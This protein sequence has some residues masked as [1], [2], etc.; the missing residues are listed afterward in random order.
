MKSYAFMCKISDLKYGIISNFKKNKILYLFSLLLSL[1]GL[2]TGI[3]VAFK[4]GVTLSTLNDFNLQIYTCNELASFNYF[5][6]RL[7]SYTLFLL[8]LFIC[9]LTVYLVPVGLI[10]IAYRTYLA[11]FNC[12]LLLTLFGISGALTSI[13]I[14]LPFQ[15]IITFLYVIYFILTINRTESKKRFGNCDISF[16]KLF[17]SFFIILTFL[18]LI[19]TILLIALN[20][21]IIFTL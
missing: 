12:T 8:I 15:L 4:C 5:F 1:V 14:I 20:A 13:I 7:I 9:S 16:C 18:N 21:S 2:L 3:F 17:F 19:Q 10:L 6:T 11:G